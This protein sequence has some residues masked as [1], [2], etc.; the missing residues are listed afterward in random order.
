[1]L[2]H[3]IAQRFRTLTIVLNFLHQVRVHPHGNGNGTVD[4][5][6]D[7]ASFQLL[8][9]MNGSADQGAFSPCDIDGIARGN[10]TV[11]HVLRRDAALRTQSGIFCKFAVDI[12]QSLHNG[13]AVALNSH[14]QTNVALRGKIGVFNN[15]LDD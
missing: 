11:Y 14:L 1:M 2:Q 13:S 3:F 7:G 12:A 10:I 6:S 4:R 9:N 15:A 5:I 8:T